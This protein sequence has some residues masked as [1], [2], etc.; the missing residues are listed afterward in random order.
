MRTY[1]VSALDVDHYYKDW[2]GHTCYVLARDPD[3]AVEVMQA[4]YPRSHPSVFG[5]HDP[6]IAGVLA[7]KKGFPLLR[8]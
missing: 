4:Y 5:G 6:A 1:R 3:H 2:Q 7:P 8:D